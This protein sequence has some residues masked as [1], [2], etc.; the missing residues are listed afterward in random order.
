MKRLALVIGHGPKID[1]GA[2]SAD[3]TTELDWNTELADLIKQNIGNA[4]DVV[5]IHRVT[6][7]IPPVAQ[8]NATAADFTVELHCNASD[9]AASGTEMI[10]LP[11]SP[12]AN[13]LATLLQ[14]AAVAVLNLKDRGVKPPQNGRGTG[15]LK[16]TKMPA[17][18]VETLFI[19]NPKDLARG[20]AVK[21]ALAAAYAKA[22]TTFAAIN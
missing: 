16:G 10:C 13:A 9:G 21:F 12:R 8:V 17:V 2:E 6:E 20:N 14:R 22:F 4:L 1:K 15:F 5:I 11:T 19:D 7:R 18:I 3:G